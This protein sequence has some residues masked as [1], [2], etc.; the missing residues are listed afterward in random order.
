MHVHMHTHTHTHTHVH[1]Y[2]HTRI[3]TGWGHLLI[4]ESLPEVLVGLPR[5]HKGGDVEADGLSP[6]QFLQQLA[7]LLS[8]MDED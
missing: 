6:N 3:H 4:M 7:S 2:I 5:P 8:H 1:L